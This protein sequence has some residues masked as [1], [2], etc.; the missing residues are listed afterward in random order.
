MNEDKFYNM[1]GLAAKAGKIVCGS[2]KVYSVIKAGKAKLLIMAADASAGT[3][4]RYS[5]K[6]ATYGAKTIR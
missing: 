6:C 2:E 3:L 1:I 4:K 5:D